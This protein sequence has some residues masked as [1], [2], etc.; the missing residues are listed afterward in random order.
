MAPVHVGDL[1]IDPRRYEVAVKGRVVALT[2]K[3]FQILA[4]LAEP[5]GEVFTKQDLI[6]NLWGDDYS[7]GS[8]SIPVYIRR[9]RKKIEEDPSNP[10]YLQTVWNFGYRLGD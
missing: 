2:P 1:V 10:R 9:I 7:K 8:V 4:F 6:K 3:E 5:L